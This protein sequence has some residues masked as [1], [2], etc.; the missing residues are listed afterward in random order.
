M[1]SPMS[2]TQRIKQEPTN[3]LHFLNLG[4]QLQ[5]DRKYA[6]AIRAYS[7]AI[8]INPINPEIHE[9]IGDCYNNLSSKKH[10]I[11]FYIRSLVYRRINDRV[12]NKIADILAQMNRHEEA[13]YCR[14][15]HGLH[16]LVYE[17]CPEYKDTGLFISDLVKK[18]NH[19]SRKTSQD[20]R[21]YDATLAQDHLLTYPVGLDQDLSQGPRS[22]TPSLQHPNTWVISLSHGYVFS[23]PQGIIVADTHQNL[24]RDFS[25]G[26]S[27]LMYHSPLRVPQFFDGKVA[28]LGSLWG[29][30][31]YHWMVDVMGRL[32]I[33]MQAGFSIKDFDCFVFDY[34]QRPYQKEILECLDIPE[35]KIISSTPHISL[36]AKV[37]MA[38]T[39]PGGIRSETVKLLKKLLL[40][41]YQHP[42][43][44]A[45]YR[46]PFRKIF[47]SRGKAQY[48][49]L[50]NEDQIWPKIEVMGFEKI[51]LEDLSLREQAMLFAE[52][53][54]IIAPHGGGLSNLMFCH[55]GISVLEIFSPDYVNPCY[56][57]M[58]SVVGLQYFYLVGESKSDDFCVMQDIEID[59][60]KFEN[61]L[62]HFLFPR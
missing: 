7:K 43:S 50:L 9:K 33:L 34:Q 5:A 20:W 57:H 48:R 52:S 53:K 60:A 58:A 42:N 1:Q 25:I 54:F 31:F 18:Q 29:E 10:A 28:F 22:I 27:I 35:D 8:A 15:A 11:S 13:G 51:F 47:V 24:L 12:Y 39:W 30:T 19:C 41:N 61:M 40:H 6:E 21:L 49:R 16:H 38:P 32:A 46:T 45:S 56:W 3:D 59:Q 2:A 14:I 23:D 36:Q 55:P 44:S 37:L 62:Q 26:D 17:F 4:D